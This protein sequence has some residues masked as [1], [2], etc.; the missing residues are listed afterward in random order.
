MKTDMTLQDSSLTHAVATVMGRVRQVSPTTI[1][2]LDVLIQRADTEGKFYILADQRGEIARA[3]DTS[4]SMV[5][6]ALRELK[7]ADLIK[8]RGKGSYSL[9]PAVPNFHA[10]ADVQSFDVVVRCTT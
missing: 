10:L 8:S 1:A 6:V 9:G 2:V 7:S 4:D 5:N 3:A